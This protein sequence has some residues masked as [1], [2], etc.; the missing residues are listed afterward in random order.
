MDDSFLKQVKQEITD[1]GAWKNEVF[2][3]GCRPLDQK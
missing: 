1:S 2:V 3:R